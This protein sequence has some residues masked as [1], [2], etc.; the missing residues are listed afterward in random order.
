M[1]SRL[2][3]SQR[4]SLTAWSFI[5][6]PVVLFIIFTLIPIVVSVF[7][8][9][10]DYDVINTPNWI[11]LANFKKM[12][13]DQFFW[14]CL[15]NTLKYTLMYVP[16][17]LVVSLASALFL[18]TRRRVADLFRTFFYIPVLSS[19]VANATL[20]L[21]ILNPQLG[22]LNRVLSI[23][24]ISGPAW[25][26]NSKTAMFAIVMMSV[27]AGF[28]ANMMIFLAGLKG[29]PSNLYES[30]RMD[31]A[32]E[33][34]IFFKITLPSLSRTTFFVSTMLIINAF[35]VF[36]QAYVL[37]KGGPGNATITLV[38]YIYNNGFKNLKM[39]YASCI[40][41]FLF[42]IIAVFSYLNML[43]NRQESDGDMIL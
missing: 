4:E 36:D 5:I 25:L 24:G 32:N 26:Y 38:Y 34:T 29:I 43:A 13:N 40:S 42:L 27:W 19:T 17:G 11:G 30:A 37:T 22:L 6:V 8:S 18:N 2:S 9:L 39:G 20:W 16:L 15:K 41:I 12:V 28:G 35:Q 10:T 21:W 23:F 1:R 14:L 7:L 33:A 3:T 31:G